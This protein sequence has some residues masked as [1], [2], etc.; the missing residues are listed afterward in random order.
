MLANKKK[1][2]EISHRLRSPHSTC[3]TESNARPSAVRTMCD[4]IA[5][6]FAMVA[7]DP[8][9]QQLVNHLIGCGLHDGSEATSAGCRHV[10][11]PDHTQHLC[12]AR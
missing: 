4:L 9:W 5:A 10:C 2:L 11:E 6:A 3:R 8:T 12:P 1:F 7:G